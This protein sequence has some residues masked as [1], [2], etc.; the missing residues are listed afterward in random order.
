MEQGNVINNEEENEIDFNIIN[1][2]LI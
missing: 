2:K 1:T